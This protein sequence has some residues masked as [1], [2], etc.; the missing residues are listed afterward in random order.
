MGGM[1]WENNAQIKTFENHLLQFEEDFHSKT[2]L[3][4]ADQITFPLST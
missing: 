1:E 4:D 3:Y 2:P